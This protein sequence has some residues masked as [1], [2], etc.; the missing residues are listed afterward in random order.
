M[1]QLVDPARGV[2]VK[3]V[4]RDDRVVAATV[5]GAP[6]TASELL[7][8]L[9]RGTPAPLGRA[10]LLLPQERGTAAAAA[11]P[12]RIPDRA[13]ICRCN[14]VTKG[15]IV[16]AFGT[17]ARSLETLAARTRATT[18]CG[19]CAD[20][21]AGLLSWLKDADAPPAS[22]PPPVP[23]APTPDQ[24]PGDSYLHTAPTGGIR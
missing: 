19:S 23:E 10:T 20:T 15:A 9:E 2:Y 7:L 13:T 17:G 22:A 8:H 1:V 18:G 6:R 11:D 16:A 14:G 24:A 5:V 3:V 12:T 4:L 21:C